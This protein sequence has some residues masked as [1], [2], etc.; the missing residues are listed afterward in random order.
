MITKLA[1]HLEISGKCLFARDF[2][3]AHTSFFFYLI[4]FSSKPVA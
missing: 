4:S 3:L 2:R 1:Y